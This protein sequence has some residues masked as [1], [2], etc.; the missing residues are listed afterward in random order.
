METT[1]A[2]IEQNALDIAAL[3]NNEAELNKL[4]S[5]VRKECIKL[6]ERFQLILEGEM[7][8]NEDN[9]YAI[10]EPFCDK[11]F[12]IYNRDWNMMSM[13]EWDEM[14]ERLEDDPFFQ[15][16]KWNLY[17]MEEELHGLKKN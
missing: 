1:Q 14:C 9:I 15:L 13:W 3:K 8:L 11:F 5:G 16:V 17:A 4:M 7:S 2:Q 10:Y 6:C 12:R